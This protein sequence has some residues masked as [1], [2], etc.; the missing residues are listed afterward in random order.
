MVKNHRFEP[1]L[2]KE[3]T[4]IGY[5]ATKKGLKPLIFLV[6]NL[7]FQHGGAKEIRTLAGLSTSAGFQDQSLKPLGYCSLL[8]K[9]GF[10]PTLLKIMVGAIGIEPM[11]FCTSNR[12]SPS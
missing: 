3:N 5:E 10:N 7:C 9:K 2:T 4:K 12:C 8:I 1:S 6:S 11:T